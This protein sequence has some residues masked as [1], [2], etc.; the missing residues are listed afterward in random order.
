MADNDMGLETLTMME[1]FTSTQNN[2]IL[3]SDGGS[4][5]RGEHGAT[6]KV[7]EI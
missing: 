3:P 6:S 4:Q 7:E 2:F 1:D 5:F